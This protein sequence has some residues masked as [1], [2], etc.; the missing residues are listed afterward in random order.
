LPETIKG[1]KMTKL[2]KNLWGKK[3]GEHLYN[4][5]EQEPSNYLYFDTGSELSLELSV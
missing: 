1:R 3:A 4:Y 5:F 2:C